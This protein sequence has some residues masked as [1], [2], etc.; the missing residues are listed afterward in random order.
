MARHRRR[1]RREHGS[2]GRKALQGDE[3]FGAVCAPYTTR[4]K[5][6]KCVNVERAGGACADANTCYSETCTGGKCVAGGKCNCGAA[7]LR[8]ARRFATLNTQPVK[9]LFFDRVADAYR[10]DD[11]ELAAFNRSCSGVAVAT[12]LCHH[13]HCHR[14]G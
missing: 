14:H 13:W 2:A 8:V 5:P 11:F 6:G 1:L 10:T 3:L 9:L 4:N 7:A 12:L